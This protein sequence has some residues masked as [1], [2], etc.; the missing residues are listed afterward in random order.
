MAKRRDWEV[1]F[2]AALMAAAPGCAG[3]SILPWSSKSQTSESAFEELAAKNAKANQQSWTEKLAIKPKVIPAKDQ[4]SL[5][6]EP[7][8]L[9]AEVFIR[10]ARIHEG[11]NNF[12][13]AKEQYE[14]AIEHEPK[15]TTALIGLA[16]LHDRQQE[17]ADAETRYRQAAQVDPNSALVWNDLGLCYARQK[18]NDEA[19]EML[20]RAIKLQPHNKM[21]RNNLA[22]VLV[23]LGRT[24]TAWAHLTAVNEPAVAHFNMGF[25]LHKQQQNDVAAQHLQM[26]LQADPSL[27]AAQKLLAKISEPAEMPTEMAEEQLAVGPGEEAPTYSI[28]DNDAP[29]TM[30]ASGGQSELVNPLAPSTRRAA[31]YRMPPVN[32]QEDDPAPVPSR[33]PQ[34]EVAAPTDPEGPQLNFPSRRIAHEE[35]GDIRQPKNVIRLL[36]GEPLTAPIPAE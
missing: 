13:D 16:R 5:S 31:T 14:R 20:D 2:L 21:Y 19:I 35:S 36:G 34:T 10:A 29:Q 26:A 32:D 24:D 27:S 9:S 22:T 28:S 1:M 18:R 8:H 4:T 7:V 3:K 6:N 33:L 17:F 25:L 12:V 15:N 30:V 23:E 11:R